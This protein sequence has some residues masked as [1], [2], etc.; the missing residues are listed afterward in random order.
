ML[1]DRYNAAYSRYQ[2]EWEKVKW[3][4]EYDLKKEELALKKSSANWDQY[5]DEQGLA[6]KY[7]EAT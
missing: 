5:M 3:E 4:K 6:L 2:T 7:A 1:E